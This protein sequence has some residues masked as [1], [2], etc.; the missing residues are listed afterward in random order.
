MPAAIAQVPF[1]TS[2][3]NHDLE[4]ATFDAVRTANFIRLANSPPLISCQ[5]NT[6]EF[7]YKTGDYKDL[8]I[9]STLVFRIEPALLD[10]PRRC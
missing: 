2:V 3:A 4:I 5:L 10:V 9:G 8:L 6:P 1:P 7:Y